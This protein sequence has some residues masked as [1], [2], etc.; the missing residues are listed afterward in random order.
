MNVVVVLK[1][2]WP[3]RS[4]VDEAHPAAMLV[5]DTIK[6][7]ARAKP[8][9]GAGGLKKITNHGSDDPKMHNT[10]AMA[11]QLAHKQTAKIKATMKSSITNA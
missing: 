2:V 10:G 6:S 3:E 9:G 5:A 11:E 4:I 8:E 1:W 7:G